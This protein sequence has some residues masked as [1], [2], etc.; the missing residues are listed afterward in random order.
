MLQIDPV[1]YLLAALMLLTLPL[2]WFLSA[3]LAAAFHELCHLAAVFLLGGKVSAARIG[4]GGAVID[5][6]LTTP[7]R[8]FL[9]ALA[10]PAGS[11]LLLAL[12]HHVPKVAICAGVQGIFNLLPIFPL[13]GGR[14]LGIVL[15]KICPK[16][17]GMVQ[18]M[19]QTGLLLAA[20]AAAVWCCFACP[21]ELWLTVLSF[22]MIIK[23]IRRK[24]PCKQ[25]E[26]RVQ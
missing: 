21:S 17:A 10:G 8:E 20:A 6:E 9:C 16:Q 5:A 24:R 22:A 11:L 4:A 2:D 14:I 15:D 12:C 3:L 25:G 19:V 13:D 1:V 23:A 18:Q 7:F 26:N